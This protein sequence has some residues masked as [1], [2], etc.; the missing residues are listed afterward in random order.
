MREAGISFFVG[1]PTWALV[2]EALANFPNTI[3]LRPN[4][5]EASRAAHALHLN[6]QQ[7]QY[8]L[9]MPMGTALGNFRR[10]PTNIILTIPHTTTEKEP[11]ADM[12]L[13][14]RRRT[15]TFTAT[16][17]DQTP[18]EPQQ[19][20]TAPRAIATATPTP[21]VL[22]PA[23][24]PQ[25]RVA[26]GAHTARLLADVAEHPYTLC[27]PSYRRCHLRLSEG[28]RAREQA[29]GLQFLRADRVTTGR[30]R[31]K[32]GISIHLT[33][34]GWAWLGTTPTKGLRGGSSPQHSFCT[35]ELARRIPEARIEEALGT[36]KS[37]DLCIPFSID[38]HEHVY[39][40]ISALTGK[41]PH[42]REGEIIAIEIDL[43]L[44]SA[45]RNATKNAAAGI[46][47][48]ILAINH[49]TPEDLAHVLPPNATVVDVYALLDAL[50]EH[51]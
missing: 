1:S 17:T 22:P 41:T 49:R 27:T 43:S 15:E 42:L 9:A 10:A 37:I 46:A 8:V 18:P 24:P 19:R 26:L 12:L 50:K 29:Q 3:A 39:R 23:T 5:A 30:G 32:T 16:Q 6:E 25:E 33:T 4:P 51:A 44:K 45:R 40:A 38:Q 36:G 47:L 28:E 11:A 31:G 20:D 21:P 13:A 48:T 14:A 35:F 2:Q 34:A 7:L